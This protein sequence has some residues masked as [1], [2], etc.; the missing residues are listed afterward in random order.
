[1]LLC[2]TGV[3]LIVIFL[4]LILYCHFLFIC[5]HLSCSEF[6]YSSNCLTIIILSHCLGVPAGWNDSLNIGS[7]AVVL[8]NGDAI[9]AAVISDAVNIMVSSPALHVVF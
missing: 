2:G 7:K 6:S 5:F 1:V 3:T 4:L 9:D 8:G